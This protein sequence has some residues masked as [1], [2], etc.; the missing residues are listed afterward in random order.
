MAQLIVRN[1]DS[2]LVRALKARAVGRGRSAEA[3]HRAI[4][5]SALGAGRTTDFK[6]YLTHIPADAEPRLRRSRDRGRKVK[7]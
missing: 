3:E 4:L 2:R 6:T 5:E 1:L 7:L